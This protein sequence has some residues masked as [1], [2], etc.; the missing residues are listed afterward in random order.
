LESKDE[1]GRYLWANRAVSDM[2][3]EEVVGKTDLEIAWAAGTEALRANDRKVLETGKTL[4]V[5]EYGHVPGRGQVT[6][7]VCK[8]LGDLDGKRCCFGV[9]FV[10][11]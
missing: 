1:E 10:I 6:L 3:K 9:S 7:K 5:Y 2:A 8:F 11:E 4:Y